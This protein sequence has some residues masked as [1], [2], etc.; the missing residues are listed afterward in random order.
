MGARSA[1]CPSRWI[2]EWQHSAYRTSRSCQ[3]CH[4]PPVEEPTPIAS[5]SGNYVRD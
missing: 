3:D 1:G 4:M 2:L 5:V